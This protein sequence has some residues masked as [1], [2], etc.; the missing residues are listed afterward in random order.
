M[1]LC[2]VLS[3][4]HLLQPDLDN[5]SFSEIHALVFYSI[6]AAEKYLTGPAAKG[7]REAVLIDVATARLFRARKFGDKLEE[8]KDG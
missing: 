2:I 1:R 6:E 8:V 5:V 4:P 7:M 3:A